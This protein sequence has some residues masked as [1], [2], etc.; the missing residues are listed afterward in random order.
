M[1]ARERLPVR[2][3]EGS[4]YLLLLLLP[5]SNAVVEL[6]FVALL[7]GWLV[8][9]PQRRRE[10]RVWP[11]AL[12][13][14][15]WS[16][17][18]FLALC[19]LSLTVSRYPHLGLRALITK[20]GEYAALFVL[21]ADLVM[22]HPA[23]FARSLVVIACSTALV[24]VEAV[25]QELRGYGLIR[26]ISVEIYDRM[27]G[28]YKDP[29]NLSTYLMVVTPLLLTFALAP[30]RPWRRWI[31]GGLLVAVLGCLARTEI[32]GAWLGVLAGMAVL[33]AGDR[34]L[35]RWGLGLALVLCLASGL[36][37]Q[38]V[39]KLEHLLSP[40]EAGKIDRRVMWGAAWNMIQDRPV[41]GH[42]LNT[43][44]ANYLDYWVGGERQPRYAHNCYLQ[45]M[46]E[47]G[48]VGLLAFGFWLATLFGALARALA[49]LPAERRGLLLGVIAALIGFL[50]QAGL[51]TN[52]YVVRQAV[53]FFAVA[54]LALGLS[55]SVRRPAGPA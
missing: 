54:G 19:A 31:L 33:A 16:L 3:Q 28:P 1:R 6:A 14:I 55:Q 29:S 47:T 39:G 32:A 11:V 40:A 51:D 2:V 30:G 15:L 13:P 7:A 53:L 4:L 23:V 48:A 27:S 35:R 34:R 5:F 24:V 21:I 25:S 43:F 20:W 17:A 18:T 42:G 8:D 44:M 52:F 38:A 10:R 50:V 49:R 26:H 37:L 45:I 36:Y 22:R 41:L 9:W 12:R 46:A